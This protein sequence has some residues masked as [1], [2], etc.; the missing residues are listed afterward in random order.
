MKCQI[1]FARFS[2]LGSMNINW[3]YQNQ[4]ITQQPGKKLE[5][6]QNSVCKIQ[7]SSPVLSSR[8]VCHIQ[9]VHFSL[10]FCLRLPFLDPIFA[11]R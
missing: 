11:R 3:I 1:F 6:M 10:R 8:L 5:Q 2:N 9:A 7:N 4:I